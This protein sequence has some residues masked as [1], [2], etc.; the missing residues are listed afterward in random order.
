MVGF[1]SPP[2]GSDHAVLLERNPGFTEWTAHS[3]AQERVED[4]EG[5]DVVHHLVGPVE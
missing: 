2:R 3:R 4:R 5:V 1:P